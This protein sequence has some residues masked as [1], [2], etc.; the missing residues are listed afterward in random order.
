MVLFCFSNNRHLY[1]PRVKL[2]LCLWQ[3]YK[4]KRRMGLYLWGRL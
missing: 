1:A 4:A 3:Y 2:Q